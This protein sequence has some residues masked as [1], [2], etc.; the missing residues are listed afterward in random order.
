MAAEAQGNTQALKVRPIT[1]A[2][3]A[4]GGEGGGVL[5]DWIVDLAQHGGYLA[6]TTSVPGVAQRTG[7]TVYYVELFPQAAAATAR[8]EPVL[9]LMPMPGDVDVVLASELMEA[10]R[11]VERGFVTPEKT[12]LIASTHRVYAMTEKI[13]LADGR[14]DAAALLAACREAA[15]QIV[16]FDMDALADAAGSVV[17]AVLF[18]A[19]AGSGALPFPRAAF[20]AA[21][22]RGQ[23]GVAK[24][25]AAFG[26]GFEAAQAGETAMPASASSAEGERHV[27]PA[28]RALIDQA[29]DDFSGEERAIVLA[30]LERLGDY[31]DAAYA[32]EFLAQ[33]EPLREIERQHGD[34]SGRLLA[35]TARH[36]ALAMAY[37]DTIRVAD[38]KIRSSRFARVRA[39]AEIADGQILEIAEFFH[40][41]TQEI[42]DTLPAPLG[43][44]L[45]RTPWARAMLD[46]ATRKGRT[47]KTTSVSGFLLLYALSRLKPLRRRSLRFATE[48]A[49][50]ADWLGLVAQTAHGDYA[51]ALQVARMRGLV[52][53]YGDTHERGQKKFE[54]LV[55]LLPRLRGRRDAPALLESLI[56]AALADETSDT[57]DKAIADL[58][59]AAAERS[60]LPRA[61]S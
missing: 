36:L 60:A 38:L 23:V 44:W 46:R 57:L 31:Q 61:A 9:G 14:V 25:L 43:R 29:G 50:L 58:S 2:V 42:A 7:A 53:G 51:L 39:E 52:K 13:A 6:Q 45:L 20:E 24:S 8:R 35:E 4:L 55:A 32:R 22:R 19:L 15:R 28:L 33:L 37:E 12:L 1:I 10:A 30:G 18:G 40:P 56:K 41:R 59:P 26:A 54:T 27:A 49:A 47:V 17:S 21:I 11:A 3:V 5:A 48:Q 34:G 16:A